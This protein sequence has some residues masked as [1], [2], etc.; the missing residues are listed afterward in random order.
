MTKEVLLA[1][2]GLQFDGNSQEDLT[3]ILPAEYYEKN[4][5]HYVIYDEVMEGFSGMTRNV[6]K[7][8]D[9]TLD[10][11][12]RGEFNVHLLF[13]ENRKNLANYATPFGELMVGIHTTNIEMEKNENLIRLDV[14]YGLE[15]NYQHLADCRI[16][17]DIR[18][19]H[20]SEGFLEKPELS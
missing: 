14:D 2:K 4:G 8:Q 10:V 11:T 19:L 20:E 15:V 3:T 13:E 5:K 17:L 16:S 7:F 12:K 6:L 18:P 1:L 9:H